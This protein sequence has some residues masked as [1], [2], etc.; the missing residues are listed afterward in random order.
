M[1]R[2]VASAAAFAV[3]AG[4]AAL[5]QPQPS[6]E[7]AAQGT[8]T[9]TMRDLDGNDIGTV[10]LMQFPGAVLVQGELSQLSPGWHAIHIH[11]VGECEPPFESAGPHFNPGGHDHGLNAVQRH[12]GDLP[13]IWVFDDGTA[14]FEMVS[15][16]IALMPLLAAAGGPQAG[17]SGA[18]AAGA[19]TG[20]AGV[21]G[22]AANVMDQDGAAIVIHAEADDYRTNPSGKSGD[23]IACGIIER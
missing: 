2:F 16:H 9:A 8:A 7:Q 21:A 15:E 13:N 17:A 19:P 5:A 1:R 10:T 11:A 23:R 22:Q 14:M 20:G 6:L 3:L 18:Q 4:G 12:A